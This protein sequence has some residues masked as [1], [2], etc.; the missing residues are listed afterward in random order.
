MAIALHDST[1]LEAGSVDAENG[2]LHR[3]KLLGRTSRNG[4]EYSDRALKEAAGFYRGLNVNIDH[5]D[6]KTPNAE[7]KVSERFGQIGDTRVEADGVYGDVKYLKSHPSAGM[8]A[9]SAQTMPGAFGFS[10]N[11]EGKKV[12]Q[13]NKWVVESIESVRSVDLVANPATTAGLYESLDETVTLTEWL[14]ASTLPQKDKLKELIEAFGQIGGQPAGQMP[15][16]RNAMQPGMQP[17]G[18]DQNG[19][20][21]KAATA[22]VTALIADQSLDAAAT[23]ERVKKVIELVKGGGEE[24][25]ADGEEPESDESE[26]GEKKPP[27][28]KKEKAVAE[29]IEAKA[30]KEKVTKLTEQVDTLTAERNA[31]AAREKARD[32]LES[33]DRDPTD[34]RIEAVVALTD[35]A[36][37]KA[38]VEGWPKKADPVQR[39]LRSA[40]LRESKTEY[41][42][43]KSF[44]ASLR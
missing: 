20:L 38:L 14:D 30:L 42:D 33:L 15:M 4:H 26:G 27:F 13:G 2:V 34:L 41:A 37:R 10:H 5:P 22:L 24:E 21:V 1:L 32:L 40:P 39:P 36:K 19:E 17:G 25:Y 7:R 18:M 8:V 11:A 29:S 9:E 43:A 35:D 6:R 44:A 16:Q 31:H 12:R 3:V 28:K 23:V